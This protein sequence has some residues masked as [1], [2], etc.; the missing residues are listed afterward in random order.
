L[1]DE[2]FDEEDEEEGRKDADVAIKIENWNAELFP[3][4]SKFN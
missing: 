4:I 3:K 2:L 1:K